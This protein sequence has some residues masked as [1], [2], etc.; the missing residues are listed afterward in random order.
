MPFASF[1]AGGILWDRATVISHPT[2]VAVRF[3]ADAT[4]AKCHPGR[5]VVGLR[6]WPLSAPD[7][8]P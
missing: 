6:G 3:V 5:L 1:H 4:L 2:V 8:P 7:S